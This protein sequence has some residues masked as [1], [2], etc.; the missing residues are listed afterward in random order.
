LD[1]LENYEFAEPAE[2]L[3]EMGDEYSMNELQPLV[4]EALKNRF[5][6]QSQKLNVDAASNSVTIS[7]SGYWPSISGNYGFSTS[8]TA[9]GDLFNRR[10]YSAGL[11]LNVP[12]F[13]GF[14]TE[15]S[16]EAAMVSEKNQ[17][18]DLL[19][20]ERSI[21]I[22]VKQGL[23]NYSAARKE[24]EV[25]KKNVRSAEESRKINNEKYNLGAGTILEVLQSVRDFTEARRQLISAEFSYNVAMNQL[26]NSL[27]ELDFAKFE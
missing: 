9:P 22:D 27:G 20:L 17:L 23:L 7:R 1:V 5:D 15:A 18:E 21:K 2:L 3:M 26:L 13:S 10:V 11:S 16:V 14:S 4:N 24:V 8:A 6:Y 12:I 25:A 19:A